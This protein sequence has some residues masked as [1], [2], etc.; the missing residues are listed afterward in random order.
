MK[1]EA[2][3]QRKI[4]VGCVWRADND[5]FRHVGQGP[6]DFPASQPEDE[7]YDVFGNPIAASWKLVRITHVRFLV[8]KKARDNAVYTN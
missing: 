5:H 6:A 2:Q 8:G 4:P 7:L 1:N 3:R